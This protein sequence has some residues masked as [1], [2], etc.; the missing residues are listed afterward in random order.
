[1]GIDSVLDTGLVLYPAIEID[2]P[3][4]AYSIKVHLL[5]EEYRRIDHRSNPIFLAL[6]FPD[7]NKE[8]V[9]TYLTPEEALYLAKALTNAANLA[10]K[11][12]R[13]EPSIEPMTEDILL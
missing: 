4:Q 2:D 8:D 6:R 12:C 13:S 3:D 10:P 11:L 7:E 9:F 5:P 1:M